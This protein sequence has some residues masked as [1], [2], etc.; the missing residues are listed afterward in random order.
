[1]TTRIPR[2]E[3]VVL[4]RVGVDFT[5]AEPRTSL[6]T[7]TSFVRAV[8]GFA[9]NIATG[10]ARLGIGTAVVSAVGDDGHAEHIR[11]ALA[12]EGISVEAIA[13]KAGRTTQVAF[14][15]VW[16]P[17]EFPVTFHRSSPAPETL[18]SPA[19]VPAQLINEA[20]L[21]I[22]SGALL[23]EE[24]TRSTVFEAL[25][26]RAAS[27]NGR[28]ASL[29]VLDLDWRPTL[30]PD[31]PAY[32]AMIASAARTCDV[33]IGGDAEF[34]AAEL[35]PEAV[36][37][38]QDGRPG[39]RI[40]VL[41][42]GPDGV[43]LLSADGRQSLDGI[44]VDV[45]CGLGSGDALTAAFTAGLLRGLEPLGA[46]ERGN[47]AGAIVATRL[48]CSSAMPRSDEIDAT[49]ARAGISVRAGATR[50]AR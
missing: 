11:S 12:A 14:F 38:S 10:L 50:M 33:I 41:K 6:A 4:G 28:A 42:H 23:A 31:P 9:G 1:M 48:L 43:S 26:G 13:T 35:R 45:M 29:T 39:S 17:S 2:L 49:V 8:G 20:P 19:D 16:P 7:A 15:E 30:W 22:V 24:P 36:A 27:R 37:L 5:P 46:L 18:L 21:V 34:A 47:A 3:A 40:V 44:V 25:D 32:P